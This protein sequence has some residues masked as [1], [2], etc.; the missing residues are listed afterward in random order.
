MK[1]FAFL[2]LIALLCSSSM[3]AYFTPTIDGTKDA[4]WGTA[5]A[6][7]HSDKEPVGSFNLINS[8]DQGIWAANDSTNLYIGLY[9]DP[10]PWADS[11]RSEL[12]FIIDTGSAGGATSNP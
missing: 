9:L 5:V 7:T 6:T 3:A 1:K 10:D 2:I 12:H 4:G 8:G 11:Q